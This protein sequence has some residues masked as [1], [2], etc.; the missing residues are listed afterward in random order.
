MN[1]STPMTVKQKELAR[2]KYEKRNRTVEQNYRGYTKRGYG[3]E[4]NSGHSNVGMERNK[5]FNSGRP[6]R[7]LAKLTVKEI[8]ADLEADEYRVSA[9]EIFCFSGRSHFLSSLYPSTLEVEGH[10][11]SSL[12]HYYQA[13]KVYTLA[14]SHYAEQLRQIGDGGRVKILAKKLLRMANV[15]SEKIDAWRRTHG[16][17]LVHHA[18]VHKFLQNPDLREKLLNTG[19]AILAH[20]YEYDNMFACACNEDAVMKWGKTM[21]GRVL[22]VPKNI[23]DDT[24][25]YVPLVGEGK[26]ILGFVSMKVRAQI[27]RYQA[28]KV[29]GVDSPPLLAAQ[30]AGIKL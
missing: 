29:E 27:R 19:N 16:A 7:A 5:G 26:N 24:L 21:H 23:D 20:T 1:M 9:N 12:E 14:G 3:F 17:I 30:F 13:C 25:D 22:K 8:P 2:E 10:N 4:N 6:P 11:Y 28:L 18:I 15:S